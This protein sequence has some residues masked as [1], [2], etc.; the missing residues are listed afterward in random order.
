[1]VVSASQLNTTVTSPV[2]TIVTSPTVSSVIPIQS[3]SALPTRV[4]PVRT[5]RLPSK[6]KGFVMH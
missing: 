6:F 4:L 1:M 2:T 5:R 3:V